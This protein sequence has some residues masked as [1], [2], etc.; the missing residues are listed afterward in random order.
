M[1]WVPVL[2]FVLEH[3]LPDLCAEV[4]AWAAYTI[5]IGSSICPVD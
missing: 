2:S 5:E 4:A 3:I 1:T